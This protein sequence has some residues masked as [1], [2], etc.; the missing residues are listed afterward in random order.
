MLLLLF[1]LLLIYLICLLF[2]LLFLLLFCFYEIF[3]LFMNTFA[4]DIDILLLFAFNTCII[5]QLIALNTTNTLTIII[6]YTILYL[7]NFILI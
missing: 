3:Y 5:E 1:C 2:Y 6:R 7:T 4:I